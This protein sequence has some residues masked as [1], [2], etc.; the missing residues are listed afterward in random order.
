MHFP[1]WYVFSSMVCIFQNGMY[2][3]AWYFLAWYVTT[4]PH[5]LHSIYIICLTKQS[6]RK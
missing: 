4:R 6:S 5:P 3:P 2:F 1:E